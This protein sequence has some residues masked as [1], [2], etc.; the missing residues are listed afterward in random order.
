MIISAAKAPNDTT[1]RMLIAAT[2]VLIFM[3]FTSSNLFVGGLCFVT[4]ITKPSIH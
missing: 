1:D 3:M 4:L 2:V